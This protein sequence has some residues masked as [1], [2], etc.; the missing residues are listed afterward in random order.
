MPEAVAGRLSPLLKQMGI[1]VQ[2]DRDREALVELAKFAL[3][4]VSGMAGIAQILA[5]LVMGAQ[6]QSMEA[7]DIRALLEHMRLSRTLGA[8]R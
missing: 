1:G 7:P 2:P 4:S 3:S 6:G 8:V 5:G